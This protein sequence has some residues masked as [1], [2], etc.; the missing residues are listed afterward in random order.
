MFKIISIVVSICACLS[1]MALQDKDSGYELKQ[2]S[3][4]S[5]YQGTLACDAEMTTGSFQNCQL[6]LSKDDI[7]LKNIEIFISGGMPA[8]QHGLP[9][10]PKIVWSKEKQVY[11]IKGLKF[12]MPGDWVLNFKINAA[13]VDDKD[14]ISMAVNVK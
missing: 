8:H 11:L 14:E 13:E 2:Q 7:A 5:V 10:T 6:K 3:K 12:S 9:T 4:N 1:L